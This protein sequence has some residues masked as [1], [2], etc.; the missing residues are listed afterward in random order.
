MAAGASGLAIDQIT[1]AMLFGKRQGCF[2]V[3]P[4]QHSL[5]SSSP[6]ADHA[7]DSEAA[8]PASESWTTAST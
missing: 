6:S 7:S 8:T 5:I 1:V 3:I 2:Q 4:L